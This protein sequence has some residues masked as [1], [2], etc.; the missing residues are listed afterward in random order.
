[1]PPGGVVLAPPGVKPV[2][3]RELPADVVLRAE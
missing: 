1:L 2:T 3:V